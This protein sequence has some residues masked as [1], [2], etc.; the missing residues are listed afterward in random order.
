MAHD[1]S[2]L[3]FVCQLDPVETTDASGRVIIAE[4]TPEASEIAKAEWIPLDKYRAMVN[5]PDTGGHPMM[6][7]VLKVLDSG[8]G[9]DRNVVKSVVPGRAPNAM[10][11]PN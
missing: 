5:N 9:I 4:P 7:H 11:C 1:R 10:Y 6:H 8:R 3:Y 2:D